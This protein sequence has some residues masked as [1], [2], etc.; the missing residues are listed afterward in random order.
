MANEFLKITFDGLDEIKY[1]LRK[2]KELIGRNAE[3]AVRNTVLYGLRLIVRDTP[4]DTGLLRS[5]ILGDF[6]GDA[7]GKEESLTRI[8]G[9]HAVIGTHLEYAVY[10]EY[11][12]QL[13]IPK[14]PKQKQLAYLFAVGILRREK[15]GIKYK[16]NARLVRTGI[17]GQPLNASLH[18]RINQRAGIRGKVKGQG[19]F[20]KNL[21]LIRA[22]FRK[23][24][25]EAIRLGLQGKAFTGI[26]EGVS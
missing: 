14:T 20:R 4:V 11:G 12:H 23:S 19:M 7:P 24:M 25:E 10:V 2:Q 18:K 15:G 16:K 17:T 26:E 8:Q 13:A 5:S 1:L 22:Y 9:L 21:P 6:G 3:A